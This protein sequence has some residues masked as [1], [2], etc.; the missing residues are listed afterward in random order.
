MEYAE[1]YERL[2]VEEYF[3][4]D[5]LN[6]VVKAFGATI[7]NLNKCIYTRYGYRSYEQMKMYD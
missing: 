1:V 3:T 5:E 6:L 2:I 4:E 7:E